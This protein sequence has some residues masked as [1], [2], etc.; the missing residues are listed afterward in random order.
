M[1]RLTIKSGSS[2]WWCIENERKE[3]V[4]APNRDTQLAF[5]RL[6]E[7]EDKLES[8]RLVELPCIKEVKGATKT[9]YHIYFIRTIE[10]NIG[11]I[12]Y[13]R[14]KDKAQAEARLRELQEKL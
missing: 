11:S 12:D 4:Y 1:E 13:Y 7:L 2:D 10:P 14:T 6:A 8:E 5:D 3:V 9:E